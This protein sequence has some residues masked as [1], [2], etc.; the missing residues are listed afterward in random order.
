MIKEEDTRAA[1]AQ[2]RSPAAGGTPPSSYYRWRW[3][4]TSGA[5]GLFLLLGS[6][7]LSVW[8]ELTADAALVRR[9]GHVARVDDY[10]RRLQQRAAATILEGWCC[11]L[12]AVRMR[13]TMRRVLVAI[14]QRYAASSSSR[15]TGIYTGIASSCVQRRLQQ[16]LLPSDGG[17]N[18]CGGAVDGSGSGCGGYSAG[19]SGGIISKD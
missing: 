19:V 12:L 13:S 2:G 1:A 16:L 5:I 3:S 15:A 14:N 17:G 9:L 10:L 6:C 11:M 4:C 8:A 18:A 7:Q